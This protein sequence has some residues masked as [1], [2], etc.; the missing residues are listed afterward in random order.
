MHRHRWTRRSL[1]PL[2]ATGLLAAAAPAL[3]TQPEILDLDVEPAALEIDGGAEG[4]WM[5][6]SVASGDVNGDGRADVVTGAGPSGTS[7]GADPDL[8]LVV[9]GATPALIDAAAVPPGGF[10][11][12]G[13]GLDPRV[14]VAGDVN[15][16]GRDD[17]LLRSEDQ[18]TGWV[19]FGRSGTRT[20]E[21]GSLGTRGYKVALGTPSGH[22]TVLAGGGDVDGDGR[23]DILA[24]RSDGTVYVVFGKASRTRQRLSDLSSGEGYVLRYTPVDGSE[25]GVGAPQAP[26]LA[27]AGD[28]NDDGR[29]DHLVGALQEWFDPISHRFTGEGS[30]W[31]VFGKDSAAEVELDDDLATS[32]YRIDAPLIGRQDSIA[33]AGDANGDG[34]PDQL[35]ATSDGVVNVVFGKRRSRSTIYL[36]QLGFGYTIVDSA[37]GG[38]GRLG[39]SLAGGVD[40][41]RDGLDDQVLGNEQRRSVYV[42]HGKRSKALIDVDESFDGYRVLGPGV[43]YDLY[44][45]FG[46]SVALGSN[47]LIPGSVFMGS[48]GAAP[49]GRDSAGAVLGLGGTFTAEPIPIQPGSTLPTP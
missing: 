29:S 14:A 39:S 35:V 25:P 13:A 2:L 41:D 22:S 43:P 1:L 30:V 7:A 27:N 19:V 16:D 17:L 44:S 49:R 37:S 5:G 46:R 38:S 36:H 18:R 6:S 11:V 12:H 47:G 24:G 32:G 21:L 45:G 4:W 28:V 26:A 10:R 34:V 15:G 31:V 48:F 40:L 33:N 3:A 42:V 23:D 20:I 8:V 9:F